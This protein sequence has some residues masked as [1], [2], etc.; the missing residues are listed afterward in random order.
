M[1]IWGKLL[2]AAAGMALGGPLGALVGAVLG[3]AVIDR[4]AARRGDADTR[5]GSARNRQVIFT[6]AAIALS[7]KMARADGAAT[8]REFVAFQRLFKVAPAEQDNVARFYRLAQQSAHGFEAYARQVRALFG[9]ETALLEDLLEALL[10]IA[11]ADG[12]LQSQERRYL[13]TVAGIFGIA[14]ERYDA[15]LQRHVGTAP[16]DPWRVLG[17]APGADA[18]AIR[19]AY[20][21]LAKAYHPDRHIAAGTPQEFLRTAEARMAAINAAY[22]QLMAGRRRADAARDAA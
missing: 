20:R 18:D 11:V 12:R 2:G 16:H 22:Q 3:H 6:I 13:D 10:L 21:R 19:A 5:A 17:L 9:S 7:A 15:M 1:S 14:G 4:P 8:A